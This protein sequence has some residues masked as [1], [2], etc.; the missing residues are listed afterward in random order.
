MF[1]PYPIEGAQLEAK[2][3]ILD[4]PSIM[5]ILGKTWKRRGKGVEKAWEKEAREMAFLGF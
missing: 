4:F 5:T 1:K 3:Q 2:S